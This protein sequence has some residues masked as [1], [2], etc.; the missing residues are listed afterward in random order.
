MSQEDIFEKVKQEFTAYLIAK[1][2]R[3]TPERYMIL[4]H[5]YTLNDHFDIDFLYNSIN[6][7]RPVVS[8]ATLYNT[9]ELL[10]DSNLVIKHSFGANMSHYEK[11]YNNDNH[12]HLICTICGDIKEIKD[13]NIKDV[14]QSKKLSKFALSHY[15]LYIYGVCNKCAKLTTKKRTSQAK[16]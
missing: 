3:K 2:H 4:K 11:A 13:H 10:V 12:L 7:E 9:M 16:K 15:S 6:S 14:I 8:R 5:I 1:G